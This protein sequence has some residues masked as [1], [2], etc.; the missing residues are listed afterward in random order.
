M[1][2]Y[3]PPRVVI[4]EN[5]AAHPAA[6]AWLAATGGGRVP[7]SVSV[8]RERPH[9]HQG[10]YR[11]AGVGVGGTVVV[12]KWGPAGPILR[13]RFIQEQVLP[14]LP[15]T[16][17][18]YYGTC[19]D[20]PDGWLFLEDVGDQRYSRSEPEHM[21]VAAEWVGTLHTV[22]SGVGAADGLADAGPSRYLRQLRGARAKVHDCLGRWTFALAEVEVL[23]SLLSWCDVLEARWGRVEAGCTGSPPTLVHGDF[24]PKNAFVRSNGHGVQIFPIDWEMAGWGPPSIDLTRIDLLAYW[25]VV[26]E[27]WVGVD[28][29]TVQRLAR[30][31]Q[32]LELVASLDWKCASLLLEQAAYRSEAVSDLALILVRLSDAARA[33]QVAE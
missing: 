20:G 23:A 27:A 11:L 7:A 32:V 26:R 30:F 33:A 16:A 29:V 2:P 3:Q 24:Q 13:E 8:M 15:L 10:I 6:K 28:F 12:A 18:R 9:H 4:T 5:V 22:A 17:P 1:K 25:R 19:L 14:Y 21:R 31:G